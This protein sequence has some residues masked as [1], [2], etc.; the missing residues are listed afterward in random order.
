MSKKI[1]PTVPKD[2]H[3]I[4]QVSGW[5][6]VSYSVYVEFERNIGDSCYAIAKFTA[7]KLND[8]PKATNKKLLKTIQKHI[9]LDD[10]KCINGEIE[11][12]SKI[13]L[14]IDFIRDSFII[15]KD[16]S[17]NIKKEERI[18]FAIKMIDHES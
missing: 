9:L 11:Y 10:V 12:F 15:Y 13:N 6:P 16:T 14:L 18:N 2:K 8:E 3:N 5:L 7:D 1:L 17:N 4:M